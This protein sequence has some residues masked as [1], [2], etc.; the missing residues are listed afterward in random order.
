MNLKD[1]AIIILI[2]IIILILFIPYDDSNSRDMQAKIDSLES[3]IF[4][5]DKL[6]SKQ[7]S[8]IDRL[9]GINDSLIEINDSLIRNE[10]QIHES[11]APVYIYIEHATN[12]Q[13]DSIVRTNW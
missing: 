1:A 8:L 11:Y 3:Q 10:Q 9:Y 6:I 13:L 7:N 12:K 5:T 4:I 2:I